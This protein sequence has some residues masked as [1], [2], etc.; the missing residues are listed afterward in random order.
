MCQQSEDFSVEVCAFV[1]KRLSDRAFVFEANAL[2]NAFGEFIHDG[3]AG[4]QPMQLV[5]LEHLSDHA[6]PDS[7]DVGLLDLGVPQVEVH[8]GSEFR[9]DVF[10][11]DQTGVPVFEDDRGR[12]TQARGEEVASAPREIIETD[13]LAGHVFP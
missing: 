5:F 13:V 8:G 2:S 9:H 7:D 12:G 11:Q 1:Q 6:S 4:G 3:R 10:H